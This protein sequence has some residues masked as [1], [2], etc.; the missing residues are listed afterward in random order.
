MYLCHHDLEEYLDY[1][2]TCVLPWFANIDKLDGSIDVVVGASVAVNQDMP[3][4]YIP[5][6][7]CSTPLI[8]VPSQL[9]GD[10]F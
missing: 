8:L 10:H 4:H 3:L 7:L 2:L 5:F 9:P 1:L 6:T